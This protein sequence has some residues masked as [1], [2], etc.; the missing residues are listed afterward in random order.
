[1]PETLRTH[2]LIDSGGESTSVN[3]ISRLS[4]AGDRAEPAGPN[5]S[6]RTGDPR[7][8]GRG[9]EVDGP[10][11]LRAGRSAGLGGGSGSAT[12]GTN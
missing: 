4:S 1:M 3:A 5:S 10:N 2:P 7:S 9:S 8:S 11:A 6:P 12:G